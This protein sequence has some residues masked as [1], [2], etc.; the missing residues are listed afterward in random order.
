[1]ARELSQSKSRHEAAMSLSA[2]KVSATTELGDGAGA[3]RLKILMIAARAFPFVGGIET[4][5]HEVSKRLAAM[6]HSVELLTTDATWSLAQQETVGGVNIV[7]VRAWPRGRDLHWAPGLLSHV[8]NG[9][10]D[11]IHVQGYHTFSAP[12]GMI[13]ALR[14]KTPFVVTFHSGGHSSNLRNAVRRLQHLLLA[15][16]MLRATQ[17][18]GVSEF[19]ADFFSQRLG[20][21][22]GAFTVVPNG[23]RLPA[24]APQA[25]TVDRLPLIL[26]VGRL[27]RYKGHH[28]IIE[29][30]ALLLKQRPDARLRILGEGPYES[31]LRRLIVSLGLQGKAEIGGIPAAEREAMAAIMRSASLVTLMSDYEAHPVAVMEALSLGLPV[32]TSDSSGF[33]ELARANLVRA[34]P[35]TADAEVLATAIREEMEKPRAPREVTLPDWDDCARRLISIYRRAARASDGSAS[36]R[37]AKARLT[38]APGGADDV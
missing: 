9:D 6:G 35:L 28:R 36:E 21:E 30:F 18:I 7:R 32:L 26:S 31:A 17:L 23:A 16:M 14:A 37:V 34:V 22:R 15:P 38:V 4:H 20:L 3:A 11:V 1:M 19:E 13:A 27:E 12:L 25:A 24:A 29:A 2:D 10:W 33:R 5:V 8:A